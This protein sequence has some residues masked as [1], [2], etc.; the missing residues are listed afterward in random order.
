[1]HSVSGT[2]SSDCDVPV[3]ELCS[4]LLC[5]CYKY[6]LGSEQPRLRMRLL[7]DKAYGIRKGRT[8]KESLEYSI[9][10][11]RKKFKKEELPNM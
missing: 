5:C 3:G 6:G 7:R 11:E 4:S 8:K 9:Q 1:M 10:A 2:L